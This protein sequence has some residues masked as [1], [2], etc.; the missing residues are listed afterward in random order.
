[1]S[2]AL[3]RLRK[4]TGDRLFERTAGAMQPTPRATAMIPGV[5]AALG[6]LR[7]TFAEQVA[8][9]AATARRAFVVASTDY[10]SAMLLPPLMAQLAREAPGV[11]LHIVGYDKRDVPAL[12]ARG[13]IDLAIGVF[14]PTP[15]D[16]V[17]TLLWQ[18]RFVGL[19]RAGHPLLGGMTA[20]AYA[21][22]AH[23]LVSVR[24][25]ARGRI[26]AALAERGLYRRISMVVPHMLALPPILGETDLLAAMPERVARHCLQWGLATF[27]L[28][29]AVP[30]WQ[31]AMLWRPAARTELASRWLRSQVKSAAGQLDRIDQTLSPIVPPPET[32]Q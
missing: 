12:V 11:D 27:E 14:D 15:P 25:D 2:A 8:F 1:M 3:G 28:P 26:D 30:A 29:I 23:A 10:T 7:T 9:D 20:E 21:G 6:Q 18:E 17:R 31:V 13:E 22:A 32:S 24:G 4:L 19:A 16:T 5:A